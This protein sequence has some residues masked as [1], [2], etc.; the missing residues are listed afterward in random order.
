MMS[1]MWCGCC[2]EYCGDSNVCQFTSVCADVVNVGCRCEECLSIE[3]KMLRCGEDQISTVNGW[4]ECA[5]FQLTVYINHVTP[6][7]SPP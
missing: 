7:F 4:H 2:C 5:S 6:I 3:L 1:R